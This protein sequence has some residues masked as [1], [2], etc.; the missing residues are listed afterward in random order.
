MEEGYLDSPISP[1]ISTG[2]RL[3]AAGEDKIPVWLLRCDT[4]HTVRR[5]E[6]SQSVHVIGKLKLQG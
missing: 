1:E 3:V 5:H 6:N 4:T 2:I